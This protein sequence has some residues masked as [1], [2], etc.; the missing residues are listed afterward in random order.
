M[1]K[2][3]V[4]ASLRKPLPEFG[5][6][7]FVHP[8]IALRSAI[9]EVDVENRCI[10]FKDG[11]VAH[12]VD[13]ILFATGYNFSFPFLPRVEIKNRR[14]QG[15]YEHIFNYRDPTLVFLGMVS[16]WKGSMCMARKC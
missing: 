14:I 13:I 9:A 6:T 8:H 7:P 10:E 5:W 1:S 4:I 11:S 12:D 15:L 2:R 3:P 16:P